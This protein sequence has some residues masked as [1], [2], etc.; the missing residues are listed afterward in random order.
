MGICGTGM[1]KTASI[2]TMPQDNCWPCILDRNCP[3]GM[4]I[5]RI[6]AELEWRELGHEFNT[7]CCGADEQGRKV[8]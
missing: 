2:R 7:L 6:L 4:G 8:I 5:G 1:K 3:A